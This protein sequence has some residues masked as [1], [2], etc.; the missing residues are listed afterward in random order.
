MSLV[1]LANLPFELMVVLA[2]GYVGY[3]IASGSIDR[4]PRPLDATFQVLVFA[5][6]AWVAFTLVSENVGLEPGATLEL[7]ASTASALLAAIAVA[8]LWRRF[9]MRISVGL[10]R[11]ARVSQENYA[12]GA[13]ENL[14]HRTDI[15]WDYITVFLRSGYVLESDLNQVPNNLPFSVCELDNDGNILLYVTSFDRPDGTEGKP[16]D[17]AFKNSRGYAQVTYVPASEVLRIEVSF[18]NG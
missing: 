3:R 16:G 12:G 7:V 2:A 4:A 8:M 6:P 13:W 11:R 14:I 18:E 1:D 9:L 15:R 5:S 17:N 10:L